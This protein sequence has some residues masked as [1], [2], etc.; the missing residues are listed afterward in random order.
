MS[1]ILSTR[2]ST[3]RKD[4]CCFGCAREFPKGTK[5]FVEA[6]ADGGSVW[7]CYL[8]RTCKE[9]VSHLAWDDEFG[10]GDLRDDAL[11]LEKGMVDRNETERKTAPNHQ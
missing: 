6:I 7:S 4:R 10:F 11:E 5:M 3:I 8:C 9:I 2:E 1:K